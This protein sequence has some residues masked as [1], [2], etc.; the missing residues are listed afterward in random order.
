LTGCER[1]QPREP[2]EDVVRRIDGITVGLVVAAL[3]LTACSSD[4]GVEEQEGDVV[5]VGD[6]PGADPTLDAEDPEGAEPGD[7]PDA[8]DDA[9]DRFEG[10]PLTDAAMTTTSSALGEHLVDGMGR[11]LYVFLADPPGESTCTGACLQ[12]WPIFSSETV[13]SV[14]G[15]VDADLVG[16]MPTSDGGSQVIYDA[17]PL[18]YYVEDQTVGDQLGQGIGDQWYLVAPDGEPITE[19]PADG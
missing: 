8:G 19:V 10:E 1:S 12:T 14:D 4:D 13:P 11:S 18:Y 2:E 15:A 6:D 17:R 3:A 16:V 9:A 7:D 5:D